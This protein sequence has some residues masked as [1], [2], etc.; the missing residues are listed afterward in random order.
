MTGNK[1]VYLLTMAFEPALAAKFTK[2]VQ[3]DDMT[4]ALD[5]VH[6]KL[7]WGIK[8]TVAGV[9]VGVGLGIRFLVGAEIGLVGEA[10]VAAQALMRRRKSRA[11]SG[12]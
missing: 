5:Y 7:E 8:V 9:A 10:E 1:I 11:E 12:R 2:A 6:F 4:G 3:A